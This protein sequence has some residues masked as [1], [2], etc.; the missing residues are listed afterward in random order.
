MCFAAN[1]EARVVNIPCQFPDY[2]IGSQTRISWIRPETRIINLYSGRRIVFF[3]GLLA[4]EPIFPSELW[5]TR[6]SP[7]D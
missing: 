4:V 6:I 3:T 1:M 7:P 2:W 5:G